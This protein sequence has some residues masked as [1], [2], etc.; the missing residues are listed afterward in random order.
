MLPKDHYM[1]RPTIH[2]ETAADPVPLT[3]PPI[4]NLIGNLSIVH[5]REEAE[6]RAER[7]ACRLEEGGH[8]KNAERASLC[9]QKE[10]SADLELLMEAGRS[11]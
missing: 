6:D 11:R 10:T 4:I 2:R 1:R 7:P 8:L 3:Q 9:L 5:E